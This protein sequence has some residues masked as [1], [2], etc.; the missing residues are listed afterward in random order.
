MLIDTGMSYIPGAASL[1]ATHCGSIRLSTL[2]CG[3]TPEAKGCILNFE[4]ETIS[5][6]D[7]FEVANKVYILLT[8]HM[9]FVLLMSWPPLCSEKCSNF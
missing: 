5:Q 8:K 6:D 2:K 4:K 3:K 7:F 1:A 9:H